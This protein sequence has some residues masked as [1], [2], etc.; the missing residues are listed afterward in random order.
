MESGDSSPFQEAQPV[1]PTKA[2]TGQRTPIKPA[3]ASRTACNFH[4]FPVSSLP[5]IMRRY[6]CARGGLTMKDSSLIA[7]ERIETAIFIIRG[8]KVMLD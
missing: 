6:N 8:E 1:A 5:S 4:Y 3:A 7:V 2:L